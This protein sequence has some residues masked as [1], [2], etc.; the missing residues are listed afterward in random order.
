[1]QA[2]R[3]GRSDTCTG[4]TQSA[5]IPYA[6]STGPHA[7][8][9]GGAP[10][11]LTANRITPPGV[12]PAAAQG[13][14]FAALLYARH[15][16]NNPLRYTDPTGHWYYDPGVDAL[17]H[18]RESG[19]EAPQNLYYVNT[20]TNRPYFPDVPQGQIQE[21][22]PVTQLI[23]SMFSEP[24]DWMMLYGQCH[25]EGCS[26]LEVGLTLLPLVPG[27]RLLE[28]LLPIQVHH[29][30]TNINKRWTPLF[31]D[32]LKNYGIKLDDAWNQINIPHSGRHANEYHEWVYQQLQVI[33][34][35][36]G[37]DKEKFLE[38]F[39]EFIKKPLQEDPG[40][41]RKAWWRE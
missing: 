28:K 31:D 3:A 8:A 2:V 34:S 15:V 32:L 19:N 23:L 6:Y 14:P 29:I 13:V 38:L 7:A 36:A 39:E 33:D 11:E 40:M 30:L 25:S 37:G 27:G 35:L 12:F 4:S 10:A 26:A 22:D 21:L 1:M 20:A 17:V 41:L 5:F 18:T 24:A 9:L 16:L